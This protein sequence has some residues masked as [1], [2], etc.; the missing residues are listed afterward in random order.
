MKEKVLTPWE[1]V[2]L[3]LSHLVVLVIRLNP[4]TLFPNTQ[5][6]GKAT[7]CHANGTSVPCCLHGFWLMKDMLWMI[8]VIALHK[9]GCRGHSLIRFWNKHLLS[10]GA[11]LSTAQQSSVKLWLTSTSLEF[12]NCLSRAVL[13]S[14]PWSPLKKLDWR[15]TWEEK[16]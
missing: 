12:K 2:Y 14:I 3:N 1:E 5:N 11:W 6:L 9:L 4:E 13:K 7:I 10:P 16:L 8:Q 15:H